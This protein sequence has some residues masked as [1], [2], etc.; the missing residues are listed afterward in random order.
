LEKKLIEKITAEEKL[1]NEIE[2]LKRQINFYKDK[3]QLEFTLKKAQEMNSRRLTAIGGG[4]IYNNLTNINNL[5]ITN[6]NV[7]KIKSSSNQDDLNTSDY[8]NS[9]NDNYKSKDSLNLVNKSTPKFDA[10][11]K[12]EFNLNDLKDDPTNKAK[13][14]LNM[15]H[16]PT[17]SD[18]MDN[19]TVNKI[20]SKKRNY[21]DNNPTLNNTSS[22]NTNKNSS[23]YDGLDNKTSG[24]NKREVTKST[25]V[26]KNVLFDLKSPQKIDNKKKFFTDSKTNNVIFKSLNLL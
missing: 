6:V 14:V 3:L 15:L 24:E 9:T 12:I 2:S 22:S 26:P 1:K 23:R 10:T 5:N 20:L 7:N 25:A 18:E 8:A 17:N 4:S 21:S 13:E 19:I 11:K 16:S